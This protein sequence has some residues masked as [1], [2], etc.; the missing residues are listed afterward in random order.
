MFSPIK[1][2]ETAVLGRKNR[3]LALLPTSL[4]N[5]EVAME[6]KGPQTTFDN[7]VKS[8]SVYILLL[9]FLRSPIFLT[10]T[11]GKLFKAEETF[12]LK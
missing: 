10:F 9:S 8:M 7:F 12:F 11:S 5:G 4:E 6:T 2:G 3:Q 1:T